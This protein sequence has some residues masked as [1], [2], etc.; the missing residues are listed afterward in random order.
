MVVLEKGYKM[1]VHRNER[2]WEMT[3]RDSGNTG[4]FLFQIHH[5]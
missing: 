3:A 2:S 1:R 4:C 5:V